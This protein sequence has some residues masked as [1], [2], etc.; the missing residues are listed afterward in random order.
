LESFCL[1]SEVVLDGASSSRI[2]SVILGG[3]RT[4]E[5]MGV[6][7]SGK[8]YDER[9]C[10]P[11]STDHDK[12]VPSIL[13]EKLLTTPCVVSAIK[14]SKLPHIEVSDVFVLTL[15]DAARLPHHEDRFL[16]LLVVQVFYAVYGLRSCI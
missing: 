12:K 1:L 16:W 15:L 7:P 3:K 6:T 13:R 4:S 14:A 11:R 5:G 10:F 8:G 2:S 9:R